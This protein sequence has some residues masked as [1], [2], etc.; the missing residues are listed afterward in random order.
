M[1]RRSLALLL[2]LA[3]SGAASAAPQ[4]VT[5]AL[6]W[7]PNVNHVGV[8]VALANRWY[9]AENVALRVLPYGSTDP[10]LLVETGRADVAVS[11]AENVTAA[12]AAG[13]PIVSIAAVYA[14]N[15]A[16]FAVL[17]NS[18]IERPRDLDG[19]IYAAFGAPYETPIVRRLITADGGKGV[20]KS[21]T[22]NVFGFDALLAKRADFVWIF[23]G[24]QGVEARRK[25]V[26]LRT[27]SLTKYGVPDYYTPVLTANRGRLATDRAKLA[28]FLRATRRG[29]EYARAHPDEAAKLMLR[30]APK[31]TFPDPGVL[32]DGLRYFAK[33]NAYAKPGARWGEQT[34]PMWTGYPK[35]LLQNAAVKDRAGRPV[36]TLDYAKLFTNDLWK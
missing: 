27:F 14:T 5:L 13:R 7:V 8:Y 1:N 2:A 24:V 18:G 31:N 4:P 36:K 22:L 23:D 9:E 32:S 20:F 15:T 17:A 25:N 33:A 12:V 35:F 30:A 28:G 3:V 16:S 34:L 10:D 26:A 29:Y 21:P 19:K 6:D 11:S